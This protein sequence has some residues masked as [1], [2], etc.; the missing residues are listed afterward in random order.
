VT[1]YLTGRLEARFRS[2][3]KTEAHAVAHADRFAVHLSGVTIRDAEL[4]DV[5]PRPGDESRTFRRARLEQ[6]RIVPRDTTGVDYI[7]NLEDV[8]AIDVE[9]HDV[10]MQDHRRFGRLTARI[11]AWLEEPTPEAK[12]EPPPPPPP[13]PIQV[14][15]PPAPPP[16][17][18][19]RAEAPDFSARPSEGSLRGLD[20]G[21]RAPRA[22]RGCASLGLPS[23]S[24]SSCGVLLW[25]FM[26]AAA[27][28]MA[29]L[30]MHAVA[31][32]YTLVARLWVVL[33]LPTVS[34][35]GLPAALRWAVQHVNWG[36]VLVLGVVGSWWL[37]R[38]RR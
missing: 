36:G 10:I 5:R 2:I 16:R 14:E 37:A 33:G 4:R 11:V 13:P 30:A 21:S 28:L 3:E 22:L 18:P 24:T 15:A 26:L 8:E 32:V 31:F 34:G 25:P 20:V 9:Y 19:L 7:A 27:V 17:P 29:L 12:P 23:C 6:V 38:R 35:E 1:Q